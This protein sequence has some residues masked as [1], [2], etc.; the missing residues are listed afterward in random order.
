MSCML[1][2][3]SSHLCCIVALQTTPLLH[4]LLLFSA[5]G[6]D[7][8]PLSE[9]E[10]V[11]LLHSNATTATGTTIIEVIDDDLL[12]LTEFFTVEVMNSVNDTFVISG[13]G[14]NIIID[15]LDNEGTGEVYNWG[16]PHTRELV[17]YSILALY[18]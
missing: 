7:F 14:S 13:N 11:T 9:T 6:S 12:E 18:F 10:L 1:C 2:K 4:V 3:R 5:L 17:E 15:I 8:F 16:K